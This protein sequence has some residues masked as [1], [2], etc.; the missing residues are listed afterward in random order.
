MM[1]LAQVT[2]IA[3]TCSP[4]TRVILGVI[5]LASHS[6]QPASREST[7]LISRAKVAVEGC[8]SLIRVDLD[9]RA[10]DRIGEDPLDGVDRRAQKRPRRL[11]VDRGVAH[12]VD[13][14]VI[15][16]DRAQGG[17]NHLH[18]RPDRAQGA[19]TVVETGGIRLRCSR[20]KRVSEDVGSELVDRA[21]VGGSIGVLRGATHAAD[22][23][24]LRREAVVDGMA[25]DARKRRDHVAHPFSEFH[26]PNP[27]RSP[28]VAV[29][30]GERTRMQTRG[31][32]LELRPHSTGRVPSADL[33]RHALELAAHGE[34]Q[35]CAELGDKALVS[36][37]DEPRGPRFERARIELLQ[38]ARVPDAPLYGP[39]VHHENAGELG[40]DR[41]ERH[42]V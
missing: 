31:E 1:S 8:R 27:S 35:A 7:S 29:A 40:G 4:S 10:R 18:A 16:P 33:D 21:I 34:R 3:S 5:D 13:G 38:L 9:H 22:R 17:N 20:E 30:V 19:R 15:R 12:E 24:R 28:R 39:V 2:Q 42:I 32:D 11:G 25:E 14:S 36:L 37:G 41:S 26:D 23:P 6:R